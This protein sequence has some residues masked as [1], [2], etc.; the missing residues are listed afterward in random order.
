MRKRLFTPE[1]A[2]E[3]IVATLR[4][5]RMIHPDEVCRGDTGADAALSARRADNK[6]NAL[7]PARKAVYKTGSA[8]RPSRV[9]F[10]GCARK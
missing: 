7:Q 10:S 9:C 6:N 8:P 3:R 1:L 5:G 4:R 2:A